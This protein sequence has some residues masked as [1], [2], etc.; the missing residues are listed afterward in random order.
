MTY[1]IISIILGGSFLAAV[2]MVCGTWLHMFQITNK[3]KEEA[4]RK[5]EKTMDDY[6]SRTATANLSSSLS[7]VFAPPVKKAG[8]TC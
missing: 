2:T 5:L 6:A 8:H 7:S 4:Y 1:V 3:Q